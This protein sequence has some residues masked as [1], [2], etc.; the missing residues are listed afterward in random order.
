[1]NSNTRSSAYLRF[2]IYYIG[3]TQS[4]NH[5]IGKNSGFIH[6][7]TLSCHQIHILS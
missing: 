2:L 1:M 4:A 7:V 5:T 3:N 6:I